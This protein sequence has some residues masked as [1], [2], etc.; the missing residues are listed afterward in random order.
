MFKMWTN[1]ATVFFFFL[2]DVDQ[3]LKVKTRQIYRNRWT[4]KV[5]IEFVLDSGSANKDSENS[6]LTAF[7]ILREL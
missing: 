5:E 4:I 6:T 3:L 2:E 7:I 1:R